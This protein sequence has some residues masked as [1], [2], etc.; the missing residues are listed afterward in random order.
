MT[1]RYLSSIKPVSLNITA[2]FFGF[3]IENK[4]ESSSVEIYSLRVTS[5]VEIFH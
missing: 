1:L 3:T 4:A 5:L 2:L